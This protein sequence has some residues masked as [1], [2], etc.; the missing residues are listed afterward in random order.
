M[1]VRAKMFLEADIRDKKH[2]RMKPAGLR[3]SRTVYQHYRLDIFRQRIHQEVRRQ[4][5]LFYLELKRAE[6][7]RKLRERRE[8]ERATGGRR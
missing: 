3:M 1:D 6:K 8:R 7:Q 5:F 2:L 4:K